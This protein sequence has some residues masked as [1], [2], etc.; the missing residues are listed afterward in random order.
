METQSKLVLFDGVCNLCNGVV[1]FVIKRDKLA[2]LKFASLQS[3]SGQHYL[4]KFDLPLSDFETFVF[5]SG[6]KYYTK[7]SAALLL[8]K[9][10]GGLW[11][12][13]YGFIIIPKFLRDA[14]YM[15][16][17]NNRY[18]LFGKQDSCMLPTPELRHRFLS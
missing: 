2:K 9:H 4:R 3:E 16:V 7:S 1:R 6:S 14:V 15:L 17:S 12:L 18:K 13:L 10:L 5:I 11:P 8:F